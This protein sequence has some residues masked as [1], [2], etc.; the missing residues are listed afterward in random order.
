[1]KLNMIDKTGLEHLTEL[2]PEILHK[3]RGMMSGDA[4]TRWFAYDG[5]NGNCYV[6]NSYKGLVKEV[7]LPFK[8]KM[9]VSFYNESEF[10]PKHHLRLIHRN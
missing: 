3:V 2:N 9:D 10:F 4:N 6:G 7:G 8:G 1:M 5:H